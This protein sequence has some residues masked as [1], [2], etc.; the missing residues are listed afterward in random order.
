MAKFILTR[1]KLRFT[2]RPGKRHQG[3]PGLFTP[4]SGL[5]K[6]GVHTDWGS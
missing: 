5:P 4:N 1:G 3:F 2:T 6:A